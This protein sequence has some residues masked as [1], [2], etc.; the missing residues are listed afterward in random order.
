[1]YR[2]DNKPSKSLIEAI[3]SVI[4]GKVIEEEKSPYE[5]KN[6]A[7]VLKAYGWK[8]TG[9][10]EWTNPNFKGEAID[11]P[12]GKGKP[13]WKHV[14]LKDKIVHD[15]ESFRGKNLYGGYEYEKYISYGTGVPNLAS[16][17]EKISNLGLTKKMF[18]Y[19]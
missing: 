17:L 10:Y 11:I 6:S 18:P 19:N 1:M 9:D 15:P 4:N 5:W 14:K 16:Y 2:S 3:E 13:N 8:K 12:G 7:Q